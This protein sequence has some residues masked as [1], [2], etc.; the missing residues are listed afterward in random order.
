MAEKNAATSKEERVVAE[1][2]RLTD[3]LAAKRAEKIGDAA[4]A[5][6]NMR[7][8]DFNADTFR[9]NFKK[10][11]RSRALS[12]A[13]MSAFLGLGSTSLAAA[14]LAYALMDLTE[15]E[16]GDENAILARAKPILDSLQA[17]DELG[18]SNKVS[19]KPK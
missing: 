9:D 3:D 16:L 11:E 4:I 10:A 13:A 1:F 12:A 7:R 14:A 6:G 19:P 17:G 2:I 8:D 18:K 5:L 15:G